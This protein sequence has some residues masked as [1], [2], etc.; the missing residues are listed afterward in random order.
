LL[1]KEGLNSADRSGSNRVEIE[2]EPTLAIAY[3]E[4]SHS[5]Y[6]LHDYPAALAA[7][8]LAIEYDPERVNLYYQRALIAKTLNNYLQVLADCEQILR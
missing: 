3:N 8:N 5:N 6:P 2:C 1:N 4:C 7:I